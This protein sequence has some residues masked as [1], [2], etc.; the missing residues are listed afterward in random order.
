MSARRAKCCYAMV[1]EFTDD[2]VGRRLWYFHPKNGVSHIL[3]TGVE[4]VTGKHRQ[5]KVGLMFDGFG[6]RGKP[7]TLTL[8]VKDFL[9]FESRLRCEKWVR[10]MLDK[11]NAEKS[12]DK[13]MGLE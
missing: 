12:M 5:D 6:R 11:S 2:L 4:H 13:F 7:L 1:T 3:V 8:W 10:A 9:F